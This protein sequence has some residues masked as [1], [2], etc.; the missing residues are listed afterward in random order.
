MKALHKHKTII[1]ILLWSLFAFWASAQKGE[2]TYQFLQLPNAARTAGLGGINIS[3]DDNDLSL[4]YCNPALL[5]D[6]LD[7]TLTLNYSNYLLDINYGY[8]AFAK[9]FGKYGTFA[10]GVFFVD[11]GHWDERDATDKLIGHFSVKEFALNLL[12]SYQLQERIRLGANLK[13]IYSVMESYK[14][15]GLALD[16]GAQY[17]SENDLFK[18]GIV[19]K[20]MGFQLSTY[21]HNNREALPFELV[22]GASQKLAHAPLR[23]SATYRHLQTFDIGYE[24]SDN[25]MNNEKTSPGFGELFMRHWVFGV[26]LLPT[27]NLYIM[28]AYNAQRRAEMKVDDNAGLIGFS[29]G[30]GI[31][32]AR[33]KVSYSSMRYHLAG[34][35]NYFSI[36]TSL[37]RFM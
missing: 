17:S 37:K 24:S 26:E 27:E 35:M 3:L 4:S 9:D 36:S 22:I 19:A 5:S 1:I 28:A 16:I 20:N 12:W 6:T 30:A 15:L 2:N 21:T 8:S 32:I 33:F 29:W 7:L 11:Y 31:E 23:I 34:R 13:P 25:T 10:A 14:S 18:M